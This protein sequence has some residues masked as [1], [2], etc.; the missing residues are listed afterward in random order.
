[1]LGP[2]W[3]LFELAY[4]LFVVLILAVY[5]AA[6]GAIGSRR[7]RRARMGRHGRARWSASPAIVAFGNKAVERLF[8]DVSYL[9]YGVYALFIVLALWKFGDRVP[10]GFAA[11]PQTSGWALSGLTYFGYNI[12]GAVVILP[13]LRHLLSDRDAVVAGVIAGPL[14][15]LPALLF[16]IPM[17]AFY[18]EVQSAT[19]PSDFMLQRIGIP[20]F[21]LLFQLMIFSALLES[22]TSSVHA[23]NERIDRAWDSAHRRDAVAPR[24]AWHRAG[25][26]SWSACS[27]PSRFGLVAL[28]A[29]GY[30][31]LAYILLAT[32]ILPL[33]T[34]GVW[35]LWHGSARRCRHPNPLQSRSDLMLKL[36]H[37]A[38]C[39][40]WRLTTVC[41]R[42]AA[43]GLRTA[44]R[45]AAQGN[46]ACPGVTIAIVED[47]KVT[48]AHG[49]GVRD[50]TTNQ[51]VDADTIFFT[52]STGKAFTNAALATLVDAGK[53]KWDDK[54][55]DHMPDFRMWDP[56]V[57]REMTI[58]DLLVHRSG[59][60]L[61][62]GDLLFLPNSTLSRKDTV[63]RIRYLKPA[64]SFR[65][66]YAY[67]NILYMAAG[68]LIEEVSGETWEQYIHDHVFGPL[69]MKHST[70]TDAEFHANPNH[71]RPHS[72]NNG[73]IHGLGTQTPLDENATIA[74]NAAPAGGLAISANDMSRWLLT[75]LGH[76]KIPGS[77]KSLFSRG[78]V[79]ADVDRRGD[80]RRSR[81][82]CRNSRSPSRTSTSTRWAG[83]FRIIAARK[84]VGHD[85]AVL[86]SQATVALAAGQERRHLHRRQQRGRRDHPR[87][88]LRA[89]RLLSRLPAG[90]LAGE[91]AQL[92]DR[93]AERGCEG[94]ADR[95]GEAGADRP[96]AAARPL[97]R[98]LYRPVVRHDQGPPGG[99]W[100]RPSISRIRRGMEGPLTHYQYDTF[101]T[102]PKLDWVEPA[103]V[104][105]SIDAERQ[106]R[107]GDDEAGLTDR[108]FQLGLPGPSVH[109]GSRAVTQKSW[110]GTT[111][112]PASPRVT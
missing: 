30:R 12:I 24:A 22:G 40:R 67:D 83:T 107:P 20:A 95:G 18:P 97:R 59:L 103:Y 48:L 8:R 25:R 110:L 45:A 74:Q 26:C 99:Q 76:G 31:A 57:T 82:S 6:A 75:Q 73:A 15:M 55:I 65:S 85:G 102:N 14:T 101:K 93:P 13:V 36:A 49:W 5:G 80:P 104:T 105:F 35:K 96:V 54:V 56:W 108:R 2:A 53:I 7:F 91:V 100:P 17:V 92:Q 38:A 106:G 87:P 23:I 60:G 42:R 98:R 77:D 4:L 1:M 21:H 37:F 81:I 64:T 70:D 71:A 29:N 44:R 72:R 61:G 69:G 27:S 19:L 90:P 39:C 89:A 9:L 78:A 94:G 33:V 46:S 34:I 41:S 63:R 10:G 50:I 88:A 3:L 62:E 112:S 11:Y 109:A 47:G 43:G 51:P 58:R 86:G 32:Y 84:V 68:Q 16:F 66:G 79:G 52:G 111:R 28:I